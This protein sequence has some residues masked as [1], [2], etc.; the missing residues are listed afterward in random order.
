MFV[1]MHIIFIF[2]AVILFLVLRERMARDHSLVINDFA[3][4]ESNLKEL[5][6]QERNLNKENE[7]RE[8]RALKIM[9]IYEV[10]KEICEFLDEDKIFP[11]FIV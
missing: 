7:S 5:T 2:T 3:A 8:E 11:G 9:N 4:I 10:T 1:I 6:S